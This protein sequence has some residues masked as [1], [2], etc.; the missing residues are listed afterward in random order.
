MNRVFVL[1]RS[2]SMASC[3][4]DTIGGFNTFVDAQKDL[5]GTMTLYLFDHEIQTLY[6][7]KP[8]SEVEPLTSNTFVPR[9]ST[10]LYD[11]IGHAVT[12][13]KVNDQTMFIILTDGHEN[14]SKN[15]SKTALKELVS[16]FKEYGAQFIFLGADE[17]SFDDANL[18]GISREDCVHFDSDDSPATFRILETC[19]RSRS[20]SA[21]DKKKKASTQ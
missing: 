16:I 10:A 5:G 20:R 9:G 4:D 15:Y 1:D 21:D 8:I 11:A 2:G 18:L 14:A 3:R 17:E 7:N 6:E 13:T 19:V 12:S